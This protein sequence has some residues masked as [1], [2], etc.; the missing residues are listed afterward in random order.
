M[1]E[2]IG[3]LLN[4][5]SHLKYYIP[6]IIEANNKK[7]YSTVFIIRNNRNKSNFDNRC[8]YKSIDILKKYSK[9]YKFNIEN[10]EKSKNINIIFDIDGEN[11]F[12]YHNTNKIISITWICDY[13]KNYSNYI[14][15]IDYCI[16][17][18]KK[19][20][21]NLFDY[22]DKKNLFLKNINKN[23]FLGSPKFDIKMDKKNLINKY[24]LSDKK[25]YLFIFLPKINTFDEKILI[26]ILNFFNKKNYFLLLKNRKKD[27]YR[28]ELIDRFPKNHLYLSV[29]CWFPHTSL[30]LIYISEFVFNF[31]SSGS[32][33]SIMLDKFII[34]YQCKSEK[35]L[36]PKINKF[37]NEIWKEFISIDSV[38]QLEEAYNTIIKYLN[39]RNLVKIFR[40]EYFSDKSASKEIIK[41]ILENKSLSKYLN[42][43]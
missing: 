24:N 17:N 19:F 1:S 37:I 38:E 26:Y 29:E 9:K 33:E 31:D 18:G 39:N 8:P 25:K 40:N 13:I 21:Y 28:K 2:K 7:I 32:I 30:E 10:I 15:N 5:M 11:K 3:F 36:A 22:I 42:I 27:D 14:D 4:S 35:Y 43:T 16:F 6:I 41:F 34:H 20:T 23:L 12:F